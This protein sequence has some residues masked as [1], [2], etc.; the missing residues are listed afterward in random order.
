MQQ[1]EDPSS[2]CNQS[3]NVSGC[4][5]HFVLKDFHRFLTMSWVTAITCQLSSPCWP[6]TLAAMS[7]LRCPQLQNSSSEIPFWMYER[8]LSFAKRVVK[9]Q[10]RCLERSPS[11]GD[12]QCAP[13]PPDTQWSSYLQS[14]WA[15]Q[16]TP[17][18]TPYK[19]P[20]WVDGLMNKLTHS[21]LHS[22]DHH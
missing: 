6:Q 3:G 15:S 21:S 2:Y 11:L 18:Q 19:W 14:T 13:L 1:N 7:H 12:V 20:K 5:W 17:E 16:L 8:N 9:P 4:R 22:P 10:S